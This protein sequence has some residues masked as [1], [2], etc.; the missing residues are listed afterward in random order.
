MDLIVLNTKTRKVQINSQLLSFTPFSRLVKSRTNDG[1]LERELKYIYLIVN[2][3]SYLKREGYEG[4]KLEAK[5]KEVCELPD[6]WSPDILVTNAIK[7]YD[8]HLEG[9]IFRKLIKT[10]IK[11]ASTS[12]KIVDNANRILDRSQ[13]DLSIILEKPQLSN[14]D[15]VT[16]DA[17]IK[18]SITSI[19][20]LLNIIKDLPDKIENIK[21]YEKRIEEEQA[22]RDEAAGGREV[23]N[24][25]LPEESGIYGSL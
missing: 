16:A 25:M 2:P 4:N 6:N 10:L 15:Y 3:L 22:A 1:L 13:D 23:D 17:T 20:S 11:S 18:A 19:N 5:A 12:Y 9:K 8:G 14:D 7:A 21:E 24:S